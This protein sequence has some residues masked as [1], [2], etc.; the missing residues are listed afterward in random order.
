MKIL[1][2][3][4]HFYPENFKCNDLAFELQKRGHKVTVMTTIPNY[5]LGKYLDGYGVFKRRREVI[6]GVTIHRSLITPRGKD[7]K[8]KLA[9]NYLTGT[10]F[11]S[12]RACLWSVTRRFDLVIVHETSPVMIGIPGVII[13]RIQ[14]IPML[15]WVLDLWPESLQAAG[16]INNPLV[17]NCFRNLTRWI[18]R[19]S[20]RILI[21]S[22]GFRRSI[23]QMGD[24]NSR[25]H[26]FPNWIDNALT[27]TTTTSSSSHSPTPQIPEF[28]KGFNVLFAGNIGKAQ[29]MPHVLDAARLLLN[30]NVNFIILGDG[31][32]RINAQQRA[33]QEGLTNVHFL[34]R[35]PLETMPD[36]F[37]KA[38]VMFL[39]LKDEPIFALTVPAKVQAYM[40]AGKPIVAMI[41]GEGADVI[42]EADCGW[43][44][45][46]ESPEALANLLRQLANSPTQLLH[47]KGQNGRQYA[48]NNYELPHCINHIEEII[49]TLP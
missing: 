31:R 25:I 40:S 2:V 49:A 41:N 18:Y 27:T 28:P 32:D 26:F 11:A 4:N 33:F 8:I 19:N 6:N 24:F 3:T 43:S 20:N 13:K 1:I 22:K 21:S 17:L 10:I 39:V 15:F 12:L 30:T 5:P 42:N 44:V 48:H 46:A 35:Y 38:D 23:C 45:P 7:N 29:D 9:L 16:D 47:Q 37:A 36:F 14:R 34:G